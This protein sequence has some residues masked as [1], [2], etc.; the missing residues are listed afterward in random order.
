MGG[1]DAAQ[2][3]A[4]GRLAYER[5]THSVVDTAG[6]ARNRAWRLQESSSAMAM[7]RPTGPSA[8]LP[9]SWSGRSP[10]RAFEPPSLGS[11]REQIVGT[12]TA[13]LG[14][15]SMP[16]GGRARIESPAGQV[17]FEEPLMRPIAVARRVALALVMTSAA[18]G[19][20]PPTPARAAGDFT[21]LISPSTQKL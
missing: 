4:A 11:D 9:E 1:C 3:F 10:P 13:I 6:L 20:F 19:S 2:A 21:L 17:P 8:A 5:A 16:V 12:N 7:L 18:V 15:R 14:V